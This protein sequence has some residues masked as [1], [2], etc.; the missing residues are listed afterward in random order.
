MKA[1]YCALQNPFE[2][3]VGEPNMLLYAIV[4]IATIPVDYVDLCAMHVLNPLCTFFP[5]SGDMRNVWVQHTA[6]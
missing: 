4:V 1:V 6:T 3:P 2:K 5:F